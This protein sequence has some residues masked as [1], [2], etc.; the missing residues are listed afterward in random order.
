[1]FTTQPS[2]S[3]CDGTG[4]R[5]DRPEKVFCPDCAGIGDLAGNPLELTCFP[6]GSESKIG[7]LAARYQL[8]LTLFNPDDAVHCPD[9]HKHVPRE[10]DSFRLSKSLPSI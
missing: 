2:C 9:Y 10:A 4:Y 7:I 1:M 6:P 8:G 5:T 3:L